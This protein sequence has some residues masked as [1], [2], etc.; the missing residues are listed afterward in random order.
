MKKKNTDKKRLIIDSAIKN[1]AAKGFERTR[2]DDIV[3]GTGLS[4]GA[5]YWYYNSKDELIFEIL[6]E[7]V[8]EIPMFKQID[9]QSDKRISTQFIDLIKS[10]MS[11]TQEY[12]VK[13]PVLME[14]YTLAARKPEYREF[15]K[16]HFNEN[17]LWIAELLSIGEKREEFD[18]GDSS[19][20]KMATTIIAM[21]EGLIVLYLLNPEIY[22]LEE[23]SI[24]AIQNIL[25]GIK[26][27]ENI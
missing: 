14:F 19:P 11:D 18:L 5:F 3:A 25:N 4:K 22:N 21:L 9:V 8:G 26:R 15:F 17:I 23:Q 12:L 1:F 13:L 6:G 27:K 16:K 2:I 7:V 24:L 10:I 20:K